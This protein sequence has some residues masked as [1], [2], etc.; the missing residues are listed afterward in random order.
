MNYEIKPQRDG[1]AIWKGDVFILWAY[2]YEWAQYKLE[3]LMEAD[4]GKTE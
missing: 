2:S 3:L 1:Y 4:K